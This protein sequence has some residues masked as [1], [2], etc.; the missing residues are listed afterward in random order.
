MNAPNARPTESVDV[1][2]VGAGM[3]GL[4]LLHRLRHMGLTARCFDAASDVGG[5]WYWNRY[6][7]AR[8]DV[9][10]IDYSYSFDSDLDDEWTW[11]ERY[12]TQPEIL[13]YLNH[14]A[15]RF[16]LRRDITFDT[17]VNSA[18]W[19]EQAERWTVQAGDEDIAARF[20]VMATGCLSVPKEI[21]IAGHE[22]FGGEV[23]VTGRWPHDEVDFTG[24]RVAVIGTGSSAIQAIPKI[25]ANADH[26]TVFQRTPN[27]SLPAHNGPPIADKVE[28]VAKDRDAYREAARWSRAG[29]PGP[30]P[31]ERALDVEADERQRRYE[32]GWA[33]GGLFSAT[34]QFAD[35]LINDEAN[36][37]LASFIRSKIHQIVDDPATA[38]MLSPTTYPMG[39][40]R[41]CLDDNYYATYNLDH[42]ELIDLRSEP[43]TTI[44]ET[45]IDTSDRS[46]EVDVIV[47]A[48]GFDAMTGALT[49]IEIA[50][51]SGTSLAE[52][53]ADGPRTY[54]GLMMVGFP[55][56]FT[57][58]GPGSPSVL[59]NMVVS[60]EQH[61]EWITDTIAHLDESGFTTI[62]PT[63]KAQQGWGQHV[64]DCANITL[65]PKAD[66]WYMGA[67]VAGKPRMFLPYVGGV[68]RYR[69]T[70]DAVVENGYLGFRLAGPDG[71]QCNDGIINRLQPDVA[72]VLDI[73]AEMGLPP[74]E[75]LG[76]DG[77][78]EFSRQSA[79]A[80]PS[81]PEIGAIIDGT[82]DGPAGPL[83][84]RAYV[85]EGAGPFEVVAYFHG[86]GW[87]LGHESSDDPFCRDLAKR[88]G[89][90]VVS[91]NY[92][93]APEHPYPAAVDD[94]AAGVRWLAANAADLGGSDG[95]MALA[96]WSA[97]ANLAAV[98]ARKLASDPA[99]DIRCQL[100][101]TPVTDAADEAPSR[102]ENGDGY[103][104]TRSLMDWFIEQ[105]VAD[106]QR[107]DPDV[108][109][110]R[111]TDLS[112][113][114]PAMVVYAEFD[115][116]RDEGIE[117][118]RALSNAGVKV[119]EVFAR[120]HVHTSLHAV[121]VVI[122]GAPVRQQMADFLDFS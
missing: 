96:G 103:I 91:L 59:S 67:N 4:Y 10:S 64:N 35:L 26:L 6:P 45:G 108:S 5:T 29:V 21:D 92:R 77:A 88:S 97:G 40:K 69:A 85:P 28:L 53:W 70:C 83:T 113:L 44:T 101:V 63:E 82:F 74:L 99:I 122:S 73:A 33:E 47:F 8:C 106:D 81:G 56:L 11:S 57:V 114:A 68:D 46:V 119:T 41:P 12:A 89:R 19:D 66:S 2:V 48:T 49:S 1:V 95:P 32:H 22:R 98:V 58:T 71:E 42:V 52:A 120:G 30:R 27:F 14:V 79:A 90:L 80:R 72:A 31:V 24:K 43:F 18:R 78:R 25:A 7:G 107:A 54:L 94:A 93:H 112:G 102:V 116:L 87:V 13:A 9:E 105:Y 3:A 65:Y 109:P 34:R 50:S 20:V 84:Y 37:T 36:D 110:L 111:A 104:L 61:V 62:E 100:L 17:K 15:D 38:D 121:D 118:A 76:P 115:P 16:D 117:Y 60:I 51:R 75:T 86:G 55:N 23:Y 39:T